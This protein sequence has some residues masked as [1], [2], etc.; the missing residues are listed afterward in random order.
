MGDGGRSAMRLAGTILVAMGA[1]MLAA[2]CSTGPSE[3]CPTDAALIAHFEEHR[4]ELT[5]LVDKP[6]DQDL[7]AAAGVLRVLREPEGRTQ[8]WMWH[9]DFP[10]PGGVV[11]GLLHGEPPPTKL[12]DSIDDNSEPGSPED[13][14]LYRSIEGQWYVFYHSSN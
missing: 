11:K 9:Q 7:L 5:K 6:G 2:S 4:A 13:E 14:E 10:G 3:P 1:W 8:L 12:V